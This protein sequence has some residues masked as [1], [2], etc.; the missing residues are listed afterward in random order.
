MTRV[1]RTLQEYNQY[2]LSKRCMHGLLVGP[3]RG[4]SGA[5]QSGS[6]AR[7][8]L[9][10]RRTYFEAVACSDDVLD[11][12]YIG[13]QA[14][15]AA[16]NWFRRHI[17]STKVRAVLAGVENSLHMGQR[18]RVSPGHPNLIR[19][20][21]TYILCSAIHGGIRYALINDISTFK[22]LTLH[23]HIITLC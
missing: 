2:W 1:A 6:P 18:A 20:P 3:I 12:L 4:V 17:R 21:L 15:S 19:T 23:C 7:D 9:L 11:R 10:K 13:E 14:Q 22:A 8:E 5:P 16:H